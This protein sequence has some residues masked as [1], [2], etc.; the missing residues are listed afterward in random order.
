MSS[1]ISIDNNK[2]LNEIIDIIKNNS[3]NKFSGDDN[4]IKEFMTKFNDYILT[5]SIDQLCVLCNIL[6]GNLILVCLFNIITIYYGD[7][8]IKYLALET[9]YPKLAKIINL[10]RKALNVYMFLNLLAIFFLIIILMLLNISY[11]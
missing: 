3:N 8:L 5:L 11:L 2:I 7:V 6:L 10:R 4:F 1:Q 9:K